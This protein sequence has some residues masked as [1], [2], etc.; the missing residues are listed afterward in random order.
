MTI[1]ISAFELALLRDLE[2]RATRNEK[3]LLM[4]NTDHQP[5]HRLVS[6]GYAACQ[7]VGADG[8]EM[9]WITEAGRAFLRSVPE[10]ATP[11]RRRGWRKGDT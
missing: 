5:M 4:R 1:E 11:G 7:R 3:A 6:V 9:C 10:R 8:T 2:R